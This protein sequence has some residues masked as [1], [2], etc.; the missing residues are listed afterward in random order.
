MKIVEL[1]NPPELLIARFMD[2]FLTS[3]WKLVYFEL[4]EG[5]KPITGIDL[6]YIQDLFLFD[7]V[8]ISLWYKNSTKSISGRIWVFHRSFRSA[9]EL[10]PTTRT[11][12]FCSNAECSLREPFCYAKRLFM[13]LVYAVFDWRRFTLSWPCLDYSR[14]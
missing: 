14:Q 10:A 8:L 5:L 1:P 2:E 11:S 3:P 13:A 6:N 9:K 12:A 7:H 4:A